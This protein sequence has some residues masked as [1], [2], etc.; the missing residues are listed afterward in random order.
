MEHRAHKKAC[1]N[2]AYTGEADKPTLLLSMKVY[3]LPAL[4]MV[5]VR[6]QPPEGPPG[7][8]PCQLWHDTAHGEHAWFQTD[9][10]ACVS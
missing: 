10:K 6:I 7:A 8:T 9:Q 2:A 5:A 1:T 4:T 3:L